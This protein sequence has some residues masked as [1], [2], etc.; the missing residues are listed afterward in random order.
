MTTLCTRIKRCLVP[1]TSM[2]TIGVVSYISWVY[3]TIYCPRMDPDDGLVLGC[4][5]VIWPTLIFIALFRII[6]GDPG[7]VTKEL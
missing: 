7:H 3:L 2:L 1:I 4:F 5:F 6:C